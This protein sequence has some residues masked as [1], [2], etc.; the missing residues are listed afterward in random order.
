MFLFFISRFKLLTMVLLHIISIFRYFDSWWCI[1]HS[2][3]RW[4]RFSI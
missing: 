2:W 3:H 4:I 1:S